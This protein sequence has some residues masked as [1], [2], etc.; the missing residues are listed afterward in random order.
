MAHWTSYPFSLMI[1]RLRKRQGWREEGRKGARRKPSM[2]SSSPVAC[3]S[4]REGRHGNAQVER[5]SGG[6]EGEESITSA[7]GVR[8]KERDDGDR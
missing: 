1:W 7:A 4:W 6:G 8:L 5:G 3:R 2:S